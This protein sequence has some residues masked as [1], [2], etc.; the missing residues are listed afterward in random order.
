MPSGKS[1]SIS[2]YGRFEMRKE[3]VASLAVI[4]LLFTI[5]GVALAWDPI[6]P[7]SPYTGNYWLV[8]TSENQV[9]TADNIRWDSTGI[10]YMRSDSNPRLDMTADCTPDNPG[11]DQLDYVVAYSDI[12]NQ[13]VTVWDDCGAFWIREEVELW[14]D[15]Q[16]VGAETNYYYQVHYRKNEWGV[17]GAINLTYQRDNEPKWNWLDKVLYSN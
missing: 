9:A 2:N 12:P 15:A 1:V 5:V 13:G 4:G 10:G 3:L 6:F 7:S 14:I 11:D 8:T 16:S 17:S